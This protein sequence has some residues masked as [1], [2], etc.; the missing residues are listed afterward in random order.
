MFTWAA[1]HLYNQ[2][3][4]PKDVCYLSYLMFESLCLKIKSDASW[5]FNDF[6]GETPSFHGWNPYFSWL[7]QG[8]PWFSSSFMVKSP[9]FHGENTTFSHASTAPHRASVA[10]ATLL[11]AAEVGD[12]AQ[13]LA[14][15]E[16]AKRRSHRSGGFMAL[17]D[18]NSHSWE[19]YGNIGYI[20]IL[21]IYLQINLY[22]YI[23]VINHY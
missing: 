15:L 6:D 12:G 21:A 14:A 18:I 11:A 10:K 7:D 5:I 2:K 22:I 16:E 17:T 8:F 4:V 23:L 3:L 19:I 1:K 13:L 20:Y 9:C